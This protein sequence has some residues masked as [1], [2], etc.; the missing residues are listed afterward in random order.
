MANFRDLIRE[1]KQ[2]ADALN[3]VKQKLWNAVAEHIISIKKG[4]MLEKRHKVLKDITEEEFKA[5]TNPDKFF[6]AILDKKKFLILKPTKPENKFHKMPK[7]NLWW[8]SPA[9]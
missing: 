9:D 8:A 6:Q 5:V 4:T 2:A 1:M 3:A 7:K